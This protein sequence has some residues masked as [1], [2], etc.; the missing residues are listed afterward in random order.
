MIRRATPD[1]IDALMPMAER[2]YTSCPWSAVADFSAES[3]RAGLLSLL[4][5]ER[6]AIFVIEAEGGA[7]LG[8]VG[9]LLAPVWLSADLILAQECFWWVEPG[10]SREAIALWKAGEDWAQSSGATA[11]SMIRL[12]GMR[13][14]ALHRLYVRRGYNP[15]EHHYVRKIG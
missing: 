12:E 10:V 5:G 2:F 7:L 13:D 15:M 14:E 11:A 1:D 9:F 8:A 6:S 4:E 3:S